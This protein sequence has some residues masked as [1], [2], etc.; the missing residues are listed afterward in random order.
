MILWVWC[1][2]LPCCDWINPCRWCSRC[3]PC[4]CPAV[5]HSSSTTRRPLLP[6][7]D[8]ARRVA[9]LPVCCRR[10][11]CPLSPMHSVAPP[12]TSP[13]SWTPCSARA[14]CRRAVKMPVRWV[15]VFL[16]RVRG[17]RFNLLA[18]RW[19]TGRQWRPADRARSHLSSGWCCLL[20]LRLC[21]AECAG[22]VYQGEQIPGLDCSEYAWCLLLCA[23]IVSFYW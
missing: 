6:A 23:V 16:E 9:A 17:L 4:A 20:W 12:R 1:M 5:V 10:L 3:D 14:T 2:T 13:W 8:W 18:S 15:F 11:S 22:C 7:G 19:L 21:Q